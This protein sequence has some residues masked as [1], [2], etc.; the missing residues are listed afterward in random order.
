VLGVAEPGLEL[1]LDGRGQRVALELLQH[2]AELDELGPRPRQRRV[3]AHVNGR[4]HF[5]ERLDVLFGERDGFDRRAG[6][7]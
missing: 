7:E 5:G 1:H 6:Q 4:V 2:V 3:L